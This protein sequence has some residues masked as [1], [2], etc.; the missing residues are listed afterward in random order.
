MLLREIFKEDASV[1]ATSAGNIAALPNPH[2]ALGNK[3]TRKKYGKGGNP[4]PPKA[5]QAKN[6][7]GTAKNALD[8]PNTSLFGGSNTIKR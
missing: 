6:A 2:V 7:D 8:L 5:V 4:K 1:G 3:S